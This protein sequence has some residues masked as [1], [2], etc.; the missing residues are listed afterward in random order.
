MHWGSMVSIVSLRYVGRNWD[1]VLDAYL[2]F[3][4]TDSIET[5]EFGAAVVMYILFHSN[6]PDQ[7]VEPSGAGHA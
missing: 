2:S 6:E 4:D 3:A 1:I 7:A 5:K